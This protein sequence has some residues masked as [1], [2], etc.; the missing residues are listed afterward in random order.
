MAYKFLP[1]DLACLSGFGE[2]ILDTASIAQKISDLD[3]GFIDN[4][5]FGLLAVVEGQPSQWHWTNCGTVRCPGADGTFTINLSTGA[6]VETKTVNISEFRDVILGFEGELPFGRSAMI[7]RAGAPGDINVARLPTDSPCTP[8]IDTPFYGPNQAFGALMLQSPDQMMIATP[9]SGSLEFLLQYKDLTSCLSGSAPVQK[10]HMEDSAVDE[11]VSKGWSPPTS[12]SEVKPH[13]MPDS[14]STIPGLPSIWTQVSWTSFGTIFLSDLDTYG[15]TPTPPKRD[16]LATTSIPGL[17][18]LSTQLSWTE[19]GTV[20]VT[21]LATYGA[22]PTATK[23]DIQKSDVSTSIVGL[24]VLS[25]QVSWTADGTVFIS[26]LATYGATPTITK[27]DIQAAAV[28]TSIPGLP[29]LSEEVTWTE[30]GTIFA[31]NLATYGAPPPLTKRDVQSLSIPGLPTLSTQ[32]FWTEDG[33]VF[34]TNLATY[35]SLPTLSVRAAAEGA[36]LEHA[37][38]QAS[39]TIPG[40]PIMSTQVSWTVD[41]TIYVTDLATYGGLPAMSARA[42]EHQPGHGNPEPSEPSITTTVTAECS[43]EPDLT[44]A[45]QYTESID[46]EYHPTT[47]V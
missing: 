33:T 10:N 45:V 43:A 23:R 38:S 12:S 40:L 31:T 36:Q 34:A 22:T 26:E 5:Y 37:D 15:A 29:I 47:S 6:G 35:G 1:A 16:I 39:T 21:D 30:D 2:K 44:A 8:N 9:T 18:V 7:T 28:T 19:D 17:P 3:L 42:V 11:S 32:V 14:F 24:P 4:T 27:R 20:Y 46:Y 13:L 41:G 25:N